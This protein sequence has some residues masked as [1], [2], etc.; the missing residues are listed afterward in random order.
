[1]THGTH[2][3]RFTKAGPETRAMSDTPARC[4]PG[5]VTS[6]NIRRTSTMGVRAPAMHRRRALATTCGVPAMAC[7]ALAMNSVEVLRV[8]GCMT[9]AVRI[10]HE[11]P[12][13]ESVVVRN[14]TPAVPRLM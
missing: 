10:A 12:K 7:C 13:V 2:P 5:R 6:A 4:H 14:F 3:M 8:R 1:M 11:S 9:G